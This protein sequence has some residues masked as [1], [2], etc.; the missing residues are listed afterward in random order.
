MRYKEGQEMNLKKLLETKDLAFSE[1]K[2]EGTNF[3]RPRNFSEFIGNTDVASL[4]KLNLFAALERNEP[5]P[6][7]LLSGLSGSGKTTLAYLI[8]SYQKGKVISAVLPISHEEWLGICAQVDQNDIVLL[9]E[10]QGAKSPE[11]LYTALE[12]SVIVH[13]GERLWIPPFTC[14][15]ATTEIG[16]VKTPLRNRFPLQIQLK[17]YS[18]DEMKRIVA[19]G[20]AKYELEIDDDALAVLAEVSNRIPREAA[21]LVVVVRNLMQLTDE[22]RITLEAVKEIIGLMKLTDDGLNLG[23]LTYLQ[24]LRDV[25]KGE[26]AGA[27]SIAAS[28]GE[29]PLTVS[30]IVEPALLQKGLIRKTSRGRQITD[31]G[32]KR[33]ESE[34]AIA[35]LKE[36]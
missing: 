1:Y 10:T 17:G 14:I 26:C 16:E 8:A 4:I 3:L 13:N 30:L 11:V 31:K 24:L 35:L 12:E 15:G 32:L 25:F 7:C 22:T 20:V 19:Q 5:F 29:N 36:E 9:D 28:L 27:N 33:L 6:H 2:I 23:H 18:L 34:D 21:S